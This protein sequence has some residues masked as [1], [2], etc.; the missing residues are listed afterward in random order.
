TAPAAGFS[1]GAK[2]LVPG[3]SGTETAAHVHDRNRTASE[4]G[5]SIDT[6]FRNEIEAIASSVGLHFSVNV[7]LNE[8][9]EIAGVFAGDK[10]A[11]WL[12]G[13]RFVEE[14]F[15]V[16]R[17]G[18]ADV[19][20]AD[21]YPFDTAWNVAN[22]RALWP[23][24]LAKRGASRVVVGEFAG[25]LGD[26]LLYPA[27]GEFRTRLARRA[28]KL[29]PGD[30]WRLPGMARGAVRLLARNRISFTLLSEGIGTEDLVRAYPK[31][32]AV[33]RWE[34]VLAGLEARHRGERV[35]AAVYRAAPLHLPERGSSS[36][37]RRE[38]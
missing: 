9:R 13:I 18:A 26:H 5:G 20:I 28:S 1:G 7:V 38:K 17:P 27:V 19:V 33:R 11:A 21:A 23:I 31:A 3:V 36:R 29:R 34:E 32:R 14:R 22:D 30:F 35:E 12:E 6:E 16:P 10:R 15:T 8:R 37:G 4:R 25:G 24:R 2:I